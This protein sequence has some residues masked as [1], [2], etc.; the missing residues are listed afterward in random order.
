M[1][2]S[3]ETCLR[4]HIYMCL[5]EC[6]CAYMSVLQNGTCKRGWGAPR[7][8]KGLEERVSAHS[9][10]CLHLLSPEGAKKD[11]LGQDRLVQGRQLLFSWSPPP[12]AHPSLSGVCRAW[13]ES[14]VL[15]S[16]DS[17]SLRCSHG[18]RLLLQDRIE[19]VWAHV[20]LHS[21]LSESIAHR[22]QGDGPSFSP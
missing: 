11:R 16:Q 17:P 8:W 3:L 2:K 13:R 12:S 14:G 20:S 7:F 9:S 10:T 15:E 19:L 4:L 5:F 6:V 22:D 1:E 18:S 21:S